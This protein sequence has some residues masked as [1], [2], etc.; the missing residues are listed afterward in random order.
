M[1]NSVRSITRF[2]NHK[3]YDSKQI[4]GSTLKKFKKLFSKIIHKFLYDKILNSLIWNFYVHRYF[5]KL[6]SGVK[7]G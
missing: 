4:N 6:K 1:V 2:C 5:D 3:F 7:I